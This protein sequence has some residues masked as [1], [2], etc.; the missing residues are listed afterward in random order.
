MS[1]RQ[2]GHKGINLTDIAALSSA[3]AM[4]LSTQ[5]YPK[6]WALVSGRSEGLV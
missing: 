5:S 1:G 3:T 6:L 2:I 4:T